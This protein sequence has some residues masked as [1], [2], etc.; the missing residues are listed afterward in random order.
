MCR[1]E[2]PAHSEQRKC[3]SASV[4]DAAPHPQSRSARAHRGGDCRRVVDAGYEVARRTVERDLGTLL[5]CMPLEINQGERPQRW[6]WKRT[7]GLDVPGMEAAEAM[8]L[9]M[10]QD[11]M[12][13]HLPSC[14]I[15][16]LHTRFAQANKTLVALARSGAHARWSDRVCIVS[17]HVVLSPPRIAAKKLRSLGATCC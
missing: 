17:S 9:Y 7:R 11:T 13:A 8:A 4:G 12:T 14:F 6:R 3:R 5:E 16:A 15:D 10:M 2:A 1:G